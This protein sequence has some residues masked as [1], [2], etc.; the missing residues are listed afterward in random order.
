MSCNPCARVAPQAASQFLAPFHRSVGHDA[1][2]GVDRKPHPY[3]PA[4]MHRDPGGS[5]G[6][7]EQ[8]VQDRPVGDRVAP[9]EHRLGL[10]ER[11]GDGAGIEMIA[12]DNDRS[13]QLSLRDTIV[14]CNPETLPLA[15]AQPADTGRK[16]LECDL[17][18]RKSDP[19]R[20]RFVVGKQLEGELIRTVRCPSRLRKERSIGTAPCPCRTWA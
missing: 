2:P 11:G 14:Q 1:E 3:P 13:G 16:P 20:E 18:P 7:V 17:L 12:A 4:M 10:A 9:V 15:V 8:G 5:A 6:S 19:S